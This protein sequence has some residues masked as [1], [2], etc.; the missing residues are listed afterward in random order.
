MA[1]DGTFNAVGENSGGYISV[2]SDLVQGLTLRPTAGG[3]VAVLEFI[4]DGTQ[5][6]AEGGTWST[7]QTIS[8]DQV[9]A[10]ITLVAGR[11]YR[12]RCTAMGTKP[13]SWRFPDDSGTP[14]ASSCYAAG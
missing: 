8:T 10:Q 4:A 2:P 12:L 6:G 3:G 13:M 11:V 7:Q 1:Y 5:N 14:G 9:N